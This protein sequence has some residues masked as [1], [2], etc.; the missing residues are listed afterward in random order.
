[1]A[2]SAPRLADVREREY[3]YS[4]F[5]R[6]FVDERWRERHIYPDSGIFWLRAPFRGNILQDE[7]ELILPGNIDECIDQGPSSPQGERCDPR[8][9]VV[10]YDPGCLQT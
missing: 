8:R 2:V 9:P 4:A 7:A 6:R 3:F 5:V 10:F 1:L